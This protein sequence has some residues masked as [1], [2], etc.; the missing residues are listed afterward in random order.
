MNILCRNG[1]HRFEPRF[2][3]AA[4]SFLAHVSVEG[5]TSINVDYEKHY[6]KDVCVRCGATVKREE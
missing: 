6:I 2:D 1:W 4:P 3:T 5:A